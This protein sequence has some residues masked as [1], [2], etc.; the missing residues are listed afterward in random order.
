MREH[1]YDLEARTSRLGKM[2]IL[3]CA[4]IKETAISRP[5]ISQLVRSATSVGANYAEANGAVSKKD[6][7]NKIHLCKK[8]LQETNYWLEMLK[9]IQTNSNTKEIRQEVS[10]LT[11]IFGK[12]I[13]TMRKKEE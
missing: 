4:S 10:E 8:E 5:L 6:F 7:R 2:V 12:I 11:R 1:K 3:Y 13:S 9:D